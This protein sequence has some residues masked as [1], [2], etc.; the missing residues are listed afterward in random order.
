MQGKVKEFN[1][2]IFLE[3]L[4]YLVFAALMIYLLGSG[5]H[6]SI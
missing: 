2:Q 5:T 4:C 6:M 3:L 1:S